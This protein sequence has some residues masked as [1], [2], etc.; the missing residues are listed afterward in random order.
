MDASEHVIVCGVDGSAA[1]QRALEWAVDEAVRRG[2][3]L[4][5]VTAWSWDGLESIGAL[6]SPAEAVARARGVLDA[7][8]DRALSGVGSPPPVER[9]ARRGVPSQELSAASADADMLVLGS[10]GHGAVHDQLVG[11]TSQRAIHQAPCPVV[12]VPDPR[13]VAKNLRRA[14]A[15][16]R[17]QHHVRPAQVG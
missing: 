5:V 1:G 16:R 4:R 7:A 10:H 13:H 8:V 15:R 6:S 12:V 2:C 14:Q 17:E 11:S 9:V 3:R